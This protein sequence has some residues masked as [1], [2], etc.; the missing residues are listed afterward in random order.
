MSFTDRTAQLKS[1]TLPYKVAGQ[2]ASIVYL[3]S[4]GGVR[5]SE[6]LQELAKNYR[7]FIPTFPGFDGT[8]T[9]DGIT[10]KQQLAEL[11][12]EF[13]D[14]EVKDKV[15][16]IGQSFGGWVAAWVGARH[17]DKLDALVLECPAG[18]IPEGKGGLSNDPEVLRRQMY[19][20]PD[21]VPPETKPLDI[22]KANRAM[23]G[24]YSQGGGGFD[25]ALVDEL[26]K[27]SCLTL[28]VAGNVD[29]VIPAESVRLLKAR[30]PRSFLVYIHEAAHNIEIDQPK[31]FLRV[32]NDFLHWGEGFLV[33]R[34]A[35]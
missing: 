20:N 26:G 23:I 8:P 9:H 17:S 28:I 7:V 34:N 4:A 6:P 2:G 15:D 22:V 35:A 21:K 27:I 31:L 25:Q 5:L 32:V 1:G 33:K 24:H 19:A 18:F 14:K 13:I 10:T 12:S 16:I 11:V 30:I 29:G 3:H